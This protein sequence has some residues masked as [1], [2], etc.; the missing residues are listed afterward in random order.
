MIEL[1]LILLVGGLVMG[2]WTNANFEAARTMNGWSASLRQKTE[3]MKKERDADGFKQVVPVRVRIS[4]HSGTG[5]E[6]REI[7]V[8]GVKPGG[9][10]WVYLKDADGQIYDL[11]TVSQVVNTETGQLIKKPFQ[12]FF[13]LKARPV[14]N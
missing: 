8:T 11:K 12:Y 6:N 13:R 1:L 2:L 5:E 4:F 7:E 3:T 9:F 14:S 10:N